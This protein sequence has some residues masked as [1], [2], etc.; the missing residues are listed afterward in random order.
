[1]KDL[2]KIS[3]SSNFKLIDA[4]ILIFNRYR[5]LIKTNSNDETIF[6]IRTVNEKVT[7]V[8]IG[9][10]W[11]RAQWISSESVKP[12]SHFETLLSDFEKKIA[13]KQKMISRI[14]PARTP[15]RF[16]SNL[17]INSA[18]KRR[19]VTPG[20]S[21]ASENEF[22]TPLKKTKQ[23]LTTLNNESLTSSPLSVR[24]TKSNKSSRSEKSSAQ[25]VLMVHSDIEAEEAEDVVYPSEED[26]PN[27]EQKSMMSRCI[28]M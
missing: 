15:S 4:R 6:D 28:I 27:N 24:S 11:S 2:P 26:E 12:E 8:F 7:E 14:S 16:I 25:Q 5:A 18:V 1:M 21:S 22:G 3:E 13:A 10:D 20:E 23:Q 9:P 19:N 17:A